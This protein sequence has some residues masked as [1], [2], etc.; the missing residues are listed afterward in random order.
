MMKHPADNR[1]EH[2]SEFHWFT[3]PIA[4]NLPAPWHDRR[5]LYGSGRDA[6]Q[7][8][9]Q[10]GRA[11]RS[12]QRLWVP[13]YFCQEVVACLCETGIRLETYPNSPIG[14]AAALDDLD[15]QDGDVLLSVN[16]F[17]LWVRP[18]YQHVPNWVEIVEDHTHDPWSPWARESRAGWC[19][20]SLRKTLP[21]GCGGVVWSPIGQSLPDALPLTPERHT[22]ALEKLAAM[23][24]K[25][26]YLSGQPVEKRVF[27]DLQ[28]SGERG[29]ASGSASGMPSWAEALLPTFPIASWRES[30]RA[31]YR[32]LAEA[33][34]TTPWVRVLQPQSSHNTCPFAGI[35]LFD[36]VPRRELVREELIAAG[37]YPAVLWSLEEPI[38]RGVRAADID[39]SRRM[40]AIH[41]DMRYTSTDMSSV[42]SLIKKIGA[43]LDN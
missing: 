35:L 8:L 13:S 42:A 10:H 37:I 36:A 38:L 23:L 24:I 5:R 30:R 18:E 43:S 14:V 34:V 11:D 22:A 6:M 39:F 15:W 32:V 1:W 25:A 2:G 12:W 21:L 4:S 19:L 27:R 41:C 16:Y 40:L 28:L 9:I 29:I 20:A 33:L 26:E 17:G 31:N 7:T 3:Y